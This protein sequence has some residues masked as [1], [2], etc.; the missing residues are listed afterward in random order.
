MLNWEE[1]RRED[2][3]NKWNE[4]LELVPVSWSISA[5]RLLVH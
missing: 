3:K 5:V 4:Y 1:K 2:M